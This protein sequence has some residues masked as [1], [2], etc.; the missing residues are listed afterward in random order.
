MR[1]FAG[2]DVGFTRTSV[3]VVDETGKIVWRGVVDTHPEMIAA[4]LHRWRGGLAKVGLESGSMSP[5][6]A[7]ALGALGFAVVCMD[8]RRAADAIKSRRVKVGQGGRLCVSGDAADGL[9]QR[10]ARE[11]R[12]EPPVQGAAGIARP[13]GTSRAALGN[14]VRGVLRPFGIRL[15]SR[16]GT[17]SF[18][19]RPIMRCATM[20]C[21]MPPMG[22]GT[23]A[24]SAESILLILQIHQEALVQQLQRVEGKFEMGLRVSWSV[25]NIFEHFVSTHRNFAN[26]RDKLFRPGCDPS[27][28]EKI[29]SVN[30]STGRSTPSGSRTRSSVVGA[31]RPA[32]F[33]IKENAV[34]DE[35]EVM[36]L[37]CL[38]GRDAQAAF[39]QSVFDAAREFN[40][41]YTFDI[42]GPFPPHNFVDL[43]LRTEE[44][45]SGSAACS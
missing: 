9:V 43:D 35:R 23:I 40:D 25:P 29:D 39:E 6:L 18:R 21:S 33:E 20:L 27:P 13:V 32:C 41:A 36:N 1:M 17:K 15:P 37:A 12:G 45:C 8:A 2:L 24:D 26:C 16:Q 3:C 30:C 22:F 19:R 10:G 7:R 11:V 14:Q 4:A 34:R 5:W 28:Q 44:I 31:L 38:V 42:S